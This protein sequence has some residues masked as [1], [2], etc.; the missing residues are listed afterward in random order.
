VLVARDR[1]RLEHLAQ[2]LAA[3]HGTV[4]E[5]LPCDLT[6]QVALQAVERRLAA[7]VDLLVN[8]A[9]FGLNHRFEKHEV[10]LEQSMLDVLVTAVLRLTHAALPAMVTR[11]S[12]AIIN[13][14]S[15]AGF[16]DLGSYS[17]AKAWVNNFTGWAHR[18][19]R[20][21]GVKII[22]LC[23]G[24]TTTEFHERMGMSERP[25]PGFMW[26]DPD[27]VAQRCLRDLERGKAFSVP[28]FQYQVMIGLVK[29]LPRT[30]AARLAAR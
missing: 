21:A 29:L 5:V 2:E 30:I 1:V 14:S 9:G 17:A 13:V 6:D 24:F 8:N 27:F 16:L 26:L 28:G 10:G 20:G 12:G 4:C 18:Q 22:A 25:G 7:G 3:Q 19:Y 11:G 15:V 23:P